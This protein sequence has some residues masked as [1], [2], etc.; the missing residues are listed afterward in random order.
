MVNQPHS[1]AEESRLVGVSLHLELHEGR[2]VA[3]DRLGHL[4]LHRVELHGSDH[5]VLVGRRRDA[6]KQQPV[7]RRIRPGKSC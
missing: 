7:L 2:G 1:E 5:A 4:P 6:D 3:L